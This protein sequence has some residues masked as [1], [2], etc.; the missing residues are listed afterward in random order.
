[1]WLKICISGKL[2]KKSNEFSSSVKCRELFDWLRNFSLLRK[3]SAPVHQSVCH[4]VSFSVREAVGQSVSH[5][6]RQSFIV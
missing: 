5:S 1:M 3:D 2:M 6:V 4:A